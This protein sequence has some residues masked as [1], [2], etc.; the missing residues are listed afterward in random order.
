MR[1]RPFARDVSRF[2]DE[3]TKGPSSAGFR[4]SD[5]PLTSLG[6]SSEEALYV[7]LSLGVCLFIV[8]WLG[9]RLARPKVSYPPG[10]IGSLLLG[11]RSNVV[12]LQNIWKEYAKWSKEYGPIIFFRSGSLN[13]LVLN[14][15]ASLTALLERRSRIYS[16]RPSSVMF[17]ELIGAEDSFSRC[18]SENPRFPIYRKMTY[19]AVG[20]RGVQEHWTVM[21]GNV[22]RYLNALRKHPKDFR[23]HVSLCSRASVLHAAYGYSAGEG[24]YFVELAD[25]WMQHINNATRPGMWLVDSYPILKYLKY[26]PPIFPKPAFLKFALS[27]KKINH[28]LL[29]GPLNWV[30]EEMSKGRAISGLA[31]KKFS[32]FSES[33]KEQTAEEEDIIAHSAWALYIAGAD[34]I[35]SSIIT[36]FLC[37][38]L[39]PDVQS[40]AQEEIDRVV[41]R[42]RLPAI[43]DRDKLP[44]VEALLKEVLRWHP[45]APL[46]LP[47]RVLRD[48]IYEG[49]FIPKHTII[50]PNI[51][52]VTHDESL[53]PSPDQFEPARHIPLAPGEP[54]PQPDPRNFVFG[55]GRRI[56]AGQHFAE[57]ALFLTIAATLATFRISKDEDEDGR[58]VEP[59]VEFAS[60]IVSKAEEF[61]C[62][63]ERRGDWIDELIDD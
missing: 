36:F 53:Y 6:L 50:I 21:E 27:Q 56:C 48:D 30:K 1:T 45:S 29:S 18:S 24:D 59:L 47:H 41:G 43:S 51:W 55:F 2:S 44:Y 58:V 33:G 4:I 61:R 5:S 38:T 40:R 7:E 63:V 23:T 37:M 46:C 35:V 60:G 34:T 9:Q 15:Q 11:A 62:K 42:N 8:V 3:A 16:D 12:G 25:R 54:P 14:S 20:P 19:E 49:M 22:R 10:P 52:A 57:A 26:L 32:E 17:G 31:A 39:N 13:Y 28:E